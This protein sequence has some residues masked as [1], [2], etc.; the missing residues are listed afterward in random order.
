MPRTD[1]WLTG[2]GNADNIS[3]KV[4]IDPSLIKGQRG[5]FGPALLINIACA[6]VADSIAGEVTLHSLEGWITWASEGNFGP[7]ILIPSQTVDPNTTSLIVPITDEQINA[8]NDRRTGDYVTLDVKLRGLATIPN[9]RVKVAQPLQGQQQLAMPR[10]ETKVVWEQSNA[11]QR[12]NIPLQTW[13]TVLKGLEAGRRRLVE[14]PEP[15]LPPADSA[16]WETC[17]GLLSKAAEAFPNET[18]KVL[19]NCRLVIEG[20]VVVVGNHFGITR[21]PNKSIAVWAKDLPDLLKPVWPNDPDASKLFLALVAAAF[22]WSSDTHHYNAKVPQRD[23]AAFARELTT[24][25]LIFGAQ[26]LE[27]TTATPLPLPAESNS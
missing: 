8:I 5:V 4:E 1:F 26:I 19:S 13:L 22:K 9:Q 27:S 25:L 12:V 14:L 16:R 2:W 21:D 17:L 24:D 18:D 10:L 15:T 11:G 23:E 20:V 3:I 7:G 6:T